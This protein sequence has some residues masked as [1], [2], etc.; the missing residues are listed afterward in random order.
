[1]AKLPGRVVELE[2]SHVRHL[3]G[4]PFPEVWTVARFRFQ[5]GWQFREGASASF[6]YSGGASK[7]RYSASAPATLELGGRLVELPSTGGVYATVAVDL[8]A[9]PGRYTLRCVKG[10]PVVDRIAAE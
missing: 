9:V 8:P 2:D 4:A 3:G 6:L 10:D 5:G 7:L 1:V